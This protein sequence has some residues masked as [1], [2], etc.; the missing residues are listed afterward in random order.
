[1]EK[2]TKKMPTQ[3]KLAPVVRQFLPGV[4]FNQVRIVF[5]YDN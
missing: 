4:P 2:K 3:V 5:C 1:M